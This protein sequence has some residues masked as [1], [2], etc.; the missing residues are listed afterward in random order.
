M[1]NESELLDV[2]SNKV[3]E[4]DDHIEEIEHSKEKSVIEN[5]GEVESHEEERMHKDYDK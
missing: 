2:S 5:I 1:R 4:L 3:L